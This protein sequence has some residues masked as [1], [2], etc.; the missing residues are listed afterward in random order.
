[1]RVIYWTWCFPY[2]WNTP[3]NTPF[4]WEQ[5]SLKREGRGAIIPETIR[6]CH[7]TTWLWPWWLWNDLWNEKN[8][9][10]PILI[11][12]PVFCFLV[13]LFF[14]FWGLHHKIAFSLLSR[15]DTVLRALAFCGLH[16]LEKQKRF[17]PKTLSLRLNWW[18]CTKTGCYST[19]KVSHKAARRIHM[20]T[21]YC[22]ENSHISLTQEPP[23]KAVGGPWWWATER[24][25]E[26]Q[27]E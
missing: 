23:G 25:R 9:G 6:N 26:R 24:V 15:E 10:I 3:C 22:P 21:G 7:Q 11:N 16:C 12:S 8:A 2:L 19:S 17:S 1:M 5:S 13:F 20:F 27:Q 4:L 18:P 14:F